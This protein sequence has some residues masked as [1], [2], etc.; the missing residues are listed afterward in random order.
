MTVTSNRVYFNSY[1]GRL[2]KWAGSSFEAIGGGMDGAIYD[3]IKTNVNLVAAKLDTLIGALAM[4]A[5]SGTVNKES[6]KVGSLSWVEPET[7]E[8]RIITPIDGSTLEFGNAT[9]DDMDI[10]IGLFVEGADLTKGLTL[11]ITE[12]RARHGS[13][14]KAA[15]RA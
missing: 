10:R 9:D 7:H 11:S 12:L 1:T 3:I 2:Y 6:L 8:P 13:V 4:L 14:S 5:F 15:H